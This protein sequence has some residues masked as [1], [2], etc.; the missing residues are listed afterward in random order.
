MISRTFSGA[1]SSLSVSAD[2]IGIVSTSSL[3]IHSFPWA[4]PMS[5]TWDFG[6]M[7]SSWGTLVTFSSTGPPAI[8]LALPY[9]RVGGVAGDPGVRDGVWPNTSV[10]ARDGVGEPWDAIVES[11]SVSWMP[12]F[13]GVLGSDG[14]M[15]SWRL[16]DTLGG[17]SGPAHSGRTCFFCFF[18]G[19]EK[20]A[21]TAKDQR[22]SF[23]SHKVDASRIVWSQI[24]CCHQ[25]KASRS[26]ISTT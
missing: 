14:F 3:F 2:I 15:S 23:Q 9:W 11:E 7:V 19:V 21:M 25:N 17:V 4:A 24:C 12:L 8:T 22:M 18:A 1:S 10:V 6:L 16:V 20:A 5:S 26:E 13:C